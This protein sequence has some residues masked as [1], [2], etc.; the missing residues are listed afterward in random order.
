V[1]ADRRKNEKDPEQ[2]MA[3]AEHPGMKGKSSLGGCDEK[4]KRHEGRA[5]D[6]ALRSIRKVGAEARR[7]SHKLHLHFDARF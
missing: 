4:K 3:R 7:A 5:R 6:R 1:V 2:T